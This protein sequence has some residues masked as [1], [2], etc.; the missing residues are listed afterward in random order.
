MITP[1]G[2]EH[3]QEEDELDLPLDM[4]MLVSDYKRTI[5]DYWDPVQR[6]HRIEAIHSETKAILRE[7]IG[8]CAV[9]EGFMHPLEDFLRG[10]LCKPRIEVQARAA[11]T[12]I[13]DSSSGFSCRNHQIAGAG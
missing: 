8:W 7:P 2:V 3:E 6:G 9:I 11:C 4:P 5:P 13:R 1:G 10:P 12:I